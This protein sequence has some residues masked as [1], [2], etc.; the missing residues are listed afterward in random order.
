MS[1][2]WRTFENECYLH[3]KNKY[4]KYA[5]FTA[6][7]QSDS[8]TPDILVTLSDNTNFYI[9]T[10]SP[11]AQSGQFVLH[12]NKNNQNFNY[13]TKN[14]TPFFPATKVIIDYM[15]NN[16][17]TFVSAG[18]KGVH[19]DLNVDILYSWIKDYY[20]S[21]GVRYFITKGNEYIIFPIEHLNK[22][23]DVSATYRIK[24]SGSSSPRKS[25]ISEIQAILQNNHI[26]GTI[27][28][29]DKEVYLK[30]NYDIGGKKL[31][32]TKYTYLFKEDINSNFSIRKLSNTK[33]VNV[34]FQIKLKKYDQDTVDLDD[35]LK[36]IA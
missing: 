30:T 27:V 8:T 7:G 5:A 32:G 2:Q 4:D 31:S 12:A 15:N 22:Y 34:I 10:K 9:E 26:S 14:H 11:N 17:D 35:F 3:L 29:L 19:I 23:F 25:N 1:E 33:N 24:K 20:S 6:Y 21:K 16:F 28:S 18:T 36:S 13:S